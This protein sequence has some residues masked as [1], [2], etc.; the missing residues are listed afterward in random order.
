[1]LRIDLNC[2]MGESADVE[3]LAAE[4]RVM[5]HVTSVNVACGIHAGS[6]EIMRRTVC[7]ARQHHLAV[8]AHPGFADVQGGGRRNL[9]LPL[10]EVENGVASQVRALAGI[11]AREGVRLTHVKP[12]GALYNMAAGDRSLAEAIIRAIVATDRQ[13]VLVGLAGSFLIEAAREAGLS[14]AEEAFADRA[15]ASDGTLVPRDRPGAVIQ[16]E[17]AAVAR[18]LR[19]V[20]EGTVRSL[21]GV[22]VPIRADTICLHGDTPGADVLARLI[23]SALDEAGVLVKALSVSGAGSHG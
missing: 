15:Y 7:L 20:R 22:D 3:R 6:P 5:S 14:A 18:A 10:E 11:A 13:L 4:E 17:R 16:D 19:L 23:R 8:G 9:T 2:D 1:M 21:D 12:H